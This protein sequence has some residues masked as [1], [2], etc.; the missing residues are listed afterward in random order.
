[1]L[2]GCRFQSKQA[3]AVC[4]QRAV[5]MRV[6]STLKAKRASAAAVVLH[7]LQCLEHRRDPLHRLQRLRYMSESYWSMFLSSSL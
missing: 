3:A 2:S 6:L 7:A 1:M 4:I 5:R